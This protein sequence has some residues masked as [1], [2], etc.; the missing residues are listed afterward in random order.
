[1]EPVKEPKEKRTVR[2]QHYVHHRAPESGEVAQT[3]TTRKV[4]WTVL[5]AQ[6]PSDA[7]LSER[8]ARDLRELC[9]AE[10]RDALITELRYKVSRREREIDE[11]RVELT[12]ARTLLDESLSYASPNQLLEQELRHA[13][14]LCQMQ[15]GHIA[16]LEKKLAE[17]ARALREK[18]APCELG[19][20][21]IQA[22]IIGAI[23]TLTPSDR[24]AQATQTDDAVH[25]SLNQLLRQEA[26]FFATDSA[27]PLSSETL[28]TPS[29]LK[30]VIM[31]A[32]ADPAGS[33][34]RRERCLA[35]FHQ[36]RAFFES[37]GAF[38]LDR[39]LLRAFAEK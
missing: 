11:L 38:G 24:A 9:T 21:G 16:Q 37:D 30:T 39:S 22:S 5:P 7:A 23:A 14:Q 6:T 35:L 32:L 34:Q 3:P 18:R 33:V 25:A 29:V 26:A 28:I 31:A 27:V 4:K 12:E 8:Q 20:R 36:E 19:R 17:Q 13:E 1:M 2:A 15:C 10:A